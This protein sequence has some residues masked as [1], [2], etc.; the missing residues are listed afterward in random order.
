MFDGDLAADGNRILNVTKLRFSYSGGLSG[1]GQLDFTNLRGTQI[2]V[3]DQLSVGRLVQPWGDCSD[4]HT[5][6]FRSMERLNGT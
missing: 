2:L 1:S 3:S 5:S 6:A 4:I